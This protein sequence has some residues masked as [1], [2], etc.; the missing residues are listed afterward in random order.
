MKLGR[1]LY[2]WFVVML[3]GIGTVGAVIT[4]YLPQANQP[5]TNQVADS[6][7]F[8]SLYAGIF[9]IVLGLATIVGYT[10][11]RLRSDGLHMLSNWEVVRQGSLASIGVT[12]VAILRGYHV[13]SWWDATLLAAALVLVELSFHVKQTAS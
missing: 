5:Y 11:R 13:F 7:V 4:S 1:V 9:L 3:V 8:A 10:F 12:A 2:G 6:F